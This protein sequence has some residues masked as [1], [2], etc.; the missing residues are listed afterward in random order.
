LYEGVKE[1]QGNQDVYQ[2][3]K[4]A[5]GQKNAGVQHKLNFN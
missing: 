1:Q 5:H 2:H 4:I 3:K